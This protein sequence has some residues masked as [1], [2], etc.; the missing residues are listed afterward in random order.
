MVAGIRDRGWSVEV[1]ELDASFPRP[2]ASAL[3]HAARTLAS[4]PDDTIAIVDGLAF[5]A[6][7]DQVARETARLRLVALVHLPLA[8]EL[9]MDAATAD[10]VD[11]NERRA[12]A[13]AQLVIVTGRSSADAVVRQGVPRERIA[14]VEPGTDRAP[15]ARGSDGTTVQLLAA[16]AVIPRKG[17]EILIRALVTIPD[18]NWHLTCAGNLDRDCSHVNRLKSLLR[19]SGLEERVSF[20]GELGATEL[21]ARYRAADVFVLPTLYETYCM[22]V[23]EALA[24]GLPVVSTS[25]GAIPQL[26]QLA[27]LDHSAGIVV[28]PGNAGALA[29]ALSRVLT[30]S[31][32]REQLARGARRVRDRLPPW[33]ESTS[34]MIAALERLAT[35]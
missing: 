19:E 3:E 27:G 34:R 9:G 18:R 11:A 12:L 33:H 2:T 10:R 29:A 13:A 30:D 22:A 32:L 31:A 28:A 7:P 6:M 26:V 1:E 23:A 25:T 5:G 4:I 24:H 8:A 21:E 17:H 20:A 15:L 35:A 16:G 14:L